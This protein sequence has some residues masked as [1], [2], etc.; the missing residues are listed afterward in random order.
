MGL[1]ASGIGS[2]LDVNGIVTQ[3]MQVESAPLTAITKKQTKING[4]ISAFGAIKSAL[5]TFQSS[6]SGLTSLS[7][8]NVMAATS[9]DPTMVSI[10]TTSSSSPGSYVVNVSQIAKAQKL[11][12]SGQKDIKTSIG[13]GTISFDFGTINNGSLDANGKYSGA[14]FSSSNAIK[15]VIVPSG[16][17]SLS[18]IRDAINSSN[19]GVTA[20]IVNDGSSTPYRLVL[21]DSTSGKQN[22]MKISVSG[23]TELGS[24]L[25]HD[26][27]SATIS[28]QALSETQTGQN[29]ELNIDG[30][31]VTSPSNTITNAING[32]TLTITKPTTTPISLA[33]TRDNAAISASITKFVTGYNAITKTLQDATAY[34]A[35]TKVASVF[36][37]DTTV[38][39][40]Q[41]QLR[42]VMNASLGSGTSVYSRLSDIGV[43]IQA[44][45]TL[46]IDQTKL[47]TAISKDANAVVN[48]FAAVGGT[49]D[50]QTNYSASNANTISGSYSV[51]V[52]S[53]ATTGKISGTSESGLTVT[54]GTND[55]LQIAIDGVSDTIK[56][57]SG[58]YTPE[59]LVKEIQLQINNSATFNNNGLSGI[60]TQSAGILSISSASYG[61]SSSAAVTGGA[62]I[63]YFFGTPNNITQGTNV[64]GSINGVVATGSQQTLIGASGDPSSG[65][66]V[67][68]S[69]GSPGDRGAVNYNQGYASKFDA[70]ITKLLSSDGQITARTTGL[71]S[72]LTSLS[73]EQD[74]T[75]TKLAVIEARYRAQYSALDALIGSMNTTSAFLTQQLA[76]L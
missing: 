9:S 60:V 35:T 14:T 61:T 18:G 24:L 36:N 73:K 48:L 49:T 72:N 42:S 20:S 54:T 70:I 41:T 13:Q 67:K 31:K 2:N 12:S 37:G 76:K 21:T 28:G 56:L 26:P 44:D 71:A 1:S 51:N 4:Q 65:I 22:S 45:G 64:A 30:I 55:S 66:A 3:L 74:K 63:E 59:N 53:L 43:A 7:N 62:N 40:L 38:K 16:N 19:I 68:I 75:T 50:N 27:A 47:N 29:A 10:A 52:S 5:S 57:T 34:N 6:M 8:L 69:G 11:V 15:T 33:V 17:T 25:N 46:G 58:T 23:D 39:G 32:V